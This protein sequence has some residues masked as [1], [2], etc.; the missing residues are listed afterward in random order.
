MK[1]L[2]KIAAVALLALALG[3]SPAW[4]QDEEKG[5]ADART[6]G[7]KV[8]D[9]VLTARYETILLF[10]EYL[11][12]FR[13]RTETVNGVMTL[14]GTVDDEIERQ[15]AESLALSIDGVKKVDNRLVV[16]PGGRSVDPEDIREKEQALQKRVADANLRAN[17]M[18]R[19]AYQLNLDADRIDVTVQDG[20]VTLDGDVY[21]EAE[22]DE[23]A[24]VA[25]DTRGVS[26]VDN[27]L[28][29]TKAETLEEAEEKVAEKDDGEQRVKTEL[30]NVGDALQD[31]WIE[32]RVEMRIAFNRHLSM[33][34]L[35][36]DV[37]DGVCTLSGELIAKEQRALAEHIAK[38]TKGVQS[39]VNE[40]VVKD[41]SAGDTD[42]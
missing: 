25:M 6:T 20:E 30:A 4:A 26:E 3:I 15:L 17:V 2:Q 7:E 14:T 28:R 41:W 21:T 42:D 12:P 34:G 18:S 40:I 35:D 8:E 33:I 38:T 22:R 13:I 31:E 39:V 27:N 1:H 32:K 9:S 16:E 10:N 24:E 37:T 5:D 19:L 36:V 29:V 11:N 23:A